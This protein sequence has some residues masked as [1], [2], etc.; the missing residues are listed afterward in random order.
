M[1]GAGRR[2]EGFVTS[3]GKQQKVRAKICRGVDF[4]FCFGKKTVGFHAA[5][6][7]ACEA[8]WPRETYAAVM[9]GGVSFLREL[10]LA[11]VTAPASSFFGP[12]FGGICWQTYVE[13]NKMNSPSREFGR[14]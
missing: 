5:I 12:A 1:Q 11:V 3:V 13:L 14:E 8:F 9:Q 4:P 7:R 10:Q 2:C 6:E